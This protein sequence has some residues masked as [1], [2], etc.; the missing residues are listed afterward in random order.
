ML[1]NKKILLAV[2]GSIA[3]YKAYEILSALKKEGADV[4]VALSDG[5]LKFC[6]LE[7]WEALC[8]HKILSSKTQ[9]WQAGINHIQ[10]GK[11]DLVLIAPASVN[12]INKLANG[13]CDSVFMQ[14]L[15][16]SSAPL[17][18]AP[19]ANNKMLEHFSTQNSIKI[20]KENG[21]KFIE[22]EN[23]ILACGDLGKGGLASI[24]SIIFE[25]K[26]M[27][28]KQSLKGKKIIITGGATIEKIDS[29]R[30]ITNFSSGKMAK[31]LA[32]ACYFAG[33]NVS[34]I[35]SFE[36]DFL[37]FD[38]VKFKSTQ[39]LLDIC[40]AKG[41]DADILIM[42]AAVSDYV[43][44]Q[45]YEGKLKKSELGKNFSLELC[46][47]IDV[48]SNLK[49]LK[50]KKIGFKLETD[51]KNALQNAKNMLKNKG[52]D[53]VCLNI[54]GEKNAFGSDEN[55]IKFIS[56]QGVIDLGF[57]TKTNLAQKLVEIVM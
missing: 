31:A 7:S 6:S 13:I 55:E 26:K 21:A 51:S 25:C 56:K 24:W 47:N 11:M 46:E 38:V 52:L 43:C 28:S 48:L 18:I 35:A 8:K 17:L 16:A 53:G 23:K 5:V 3:F 9:D 50:C 12:T 22:P 27:L 30:A 29:V 40:K 39:E 14:T 10:Y 36:T 45:T 4:Y 2:C 33:A 57:D 49:D 34:L 1:K 44:K 42:C 54:L 37:P 15:I 20:L 19:A 32:N 41:K